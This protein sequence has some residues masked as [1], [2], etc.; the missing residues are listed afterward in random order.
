MADDNFKSIENRPN[1]FLRVLRLIADFLGFSRN[2]EYVKRHIALANIRSGIFMGGTVA[3]LE[4]W[5]FFRQLNKYIIPEWGSR[6]PSGIM[7]YTSIFILFFLV[8]LSI[9][10]FSLTFDSKKIRRKVKFILNIV[11]AGATA[12]Y[13]IYAFFE[14]YSEYDTSRHIISNITLMV[15][16]LSAFLTSAAIIAYSLFDLLKPKERLLFAKSIFVLFAIMCFAFGIK[17]SY[18]DYTS[19]NQKQIL[20]FLTMAIYG[21]GMIIWRPWI[22]LVVNVGVFFGFYGLLVSAGTVKG[23]TFND[24]D[25]VNYITF[26]VAFTTICISIYHQRFR[27]AKKSED[28]EYSATHDTLTGITNHVTFAHNV[29]D[30]I[31]VD[32]EKTQTHVLAFTNIP[33]FKILN[34]RRGFGQGNAF[35]R[36]LGH[37]IE[38]IFE[39]HSV[40]RQSDDHFILYAPRIDLEEKMRKVRAFISDREPELGLMMQYG[41]YALKNGED[42]FA[43]TDKARYACSLLKSDHTKFYL[44]YDEEME[45]RYELIQHIIHTLDK[46]IEEDYIRPYYQPVVWSEDQTLCGA[47]ALC[48]WIDPEHGFISPGVFI[49]VLESTKLCYK[50]DAHI[51]RC[52]CRDLRQRLNRGL[53]VFPISVNFSRRD[54]SAMD[55]TKLLDETLATFDIDK[56]LIHVEITES[57][58]TDSESALGSTLKKL[59]EKG[60]SLWLD[61][62]GSGYSSLNV[63]KDFHF[64]VMKIDLKFLEGFDDNDQSKPLIDSVITMAKKLGMR[65][66]CEGVETPSQEEFLR[67]AG[68]ERLQGYLFGKAIPIEEFNGKLL[69]RSFIISDHLI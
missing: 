43:A 69:D 3:I 6:G 30:E 48:R 40:C 57:A 32:P 46:A 14:P 35:L 11:C 28:L 27:E 12:L 62:F 55:V 24:G 9:L 16:Y 33:N 10:V 63:L 54:F 20:C 37:E 21:A 49:P 36:D 45:R 25:L 7:F 31:K 52:V 13:C 15:T 60:Y 53:P 29:A 41:I 2:S 42:P 26:L 4:V 22:S 65:T 66:L 44:E 67:K 59:K 58:L 68:C 51:L 23:T 56:S 61:D 64:D 39:G 19:S 1:A 8:G 5:L 50:L 47:E 17:V 38:K 34:D 18:G